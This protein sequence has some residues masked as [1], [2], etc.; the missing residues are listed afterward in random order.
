MTIKRYVIAITGAS[1]VIYGVELLKYLKNNTNFEIYL[2][3]SKNAIK[4]LKYELNIDIN[5]LKNLCTYMF[6]DNDLDA[7]IAS[8]SYIFHGM[9]IIP[10]STKTLACIANGISNNL[11]TRTAEVCLKEKRKLILVIR[12][13]P[14]NLIHALNIVKVIKAGAIVLPACPAFYHKPKTINDLVNYIV[15]KVL[16]L[17]EIEHNLYVRWNRK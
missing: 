14:L 4:I 6:S 2:I 5:D 11:I 1:G 9:V 8:G 12:E 17:L 10:C 16:D 13:T 7:P 15:G 3:V